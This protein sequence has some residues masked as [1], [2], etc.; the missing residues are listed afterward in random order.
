MS[1]LGRRGVHAAAAPLRAGLGF[2]AGFRYPLR[3]GRF[4]YVEHRSLARYWIWP[5]LI[6]VVALVGVGFGA[7]HA[8]ELLGELWTRPPASASAWLRFAYGA[9]S[10]LAGVLIALFGLIT[11]ALLTSVIAAPFNDLLSEEVERLATGQPPLPFRLRKMLADLVRTVRLELTKLGLYLAVMVPAWLLS[12][13]VPGVG[14]VVYTVFAFGFTATYFALDYIDWPASRRD[15]AVRERLRM[16]RRHLPTML[17]FG[18]G[19]WVLLFIPFVNLF[20]MPAAVA[21]GTL[22]FLDVDGSATGASA[23][24]APSTPSFP[25]PTSGQESS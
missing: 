23:P 16:V 21:G 6:T 11:V 7:A 19:V 15:R 4:V 17:G 5:I 3:G 25:R 2:A 9:A 14:Q 12:W 10:V 1:D 18:T 8:A 24:V 22:L 13:I 20:F